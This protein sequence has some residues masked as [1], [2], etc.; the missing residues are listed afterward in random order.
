MSYANT[1]DKN[2]YLHLESA[3]AFYKVENSFFH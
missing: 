3:A 1:D 2:R